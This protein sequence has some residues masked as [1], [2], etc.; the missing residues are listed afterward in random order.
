MTIDPFPPE[1][2]AQFEELARLSQLLEATQASAATR[3]REFAQAAS[4]WERTAAALTREIAA[5]QQII[6]SRELEIKSLKLELEAIYA[7]SSW[8]LTAPLRSAIEHLS[9]L[10][11]RRSKNGHAASSQHSRRASS[12]N[13][14]LSVL[15]Q[16]VE[17]HSPL[18]SSI[19][20]KPSPKSVAPVMTKLVVVDQ[21]NTSEEPELVQRIYRQF[22]RARK[23]ALENR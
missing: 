6:A 9:N 3:H 20:G 7:S 16:S 8:R 10:W 2:S 4:E 11:S 14:S 12:D 5:Q 18:Y 21:L 1:R 13:G 17:G 23:Q 19:E 22:T 15:Q